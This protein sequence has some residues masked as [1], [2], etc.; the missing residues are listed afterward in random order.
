MAIITEEER[1]PEIKETT[2]T[3]LKT[4]SSSSSPTLNP[5]VTAHDLGSSPTANAFK[6]WAYFTF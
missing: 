1:E 6:F 4:N 5:D 2:T 3:P